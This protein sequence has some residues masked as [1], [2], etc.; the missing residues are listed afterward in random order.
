MHQVICVS[1]LIECE[2][3]K[4]NTHSHRTFDRCS[5][6]A[7]RSIFATVCRLCF[8][9]VFLGRESAGAVETILANIET[10]RAEEKDIAAPSDDDVA[11]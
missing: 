10:A 6:R 9:P 5:E 3:K 11:P 4:L 2:K 7:F 8:L 1:I